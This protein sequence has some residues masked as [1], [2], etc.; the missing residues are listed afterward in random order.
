MRIVLIGGH[1]TPLLAVIKELQKQESVEIIVIT[2]KFSMEGSKKQSVESQVLQRLGIRFHYIITGRLQRHF[3]AHTFTSLAKIP[4][5]FIQSLLLLRTIRPNVVV[6]FGSYLSV[7]VC[8]SAWLF[9]IPILVHEQSSR[10]GLANRL[11]AKLA[12]KVAV[13]WPAS[14][15][16]FPKNKTVLTGNP[17][18][19]EIFQQSAEGALVAFLQSDTLPLIYVTGGNQGSHIINTTIFDILPVLLRNFR[20]IHQT[21]DAA[22]HDYERAIDLHK[23][24]PSELAQAYFVTKFIHSEDI[25]GVLHEA[26]LVISRAGAN[27][28]TELMYLGK[29]AILVPIPWAQQNEQLENAKI[30]QQQGFV[31][32]IEQKRLSG[33]VLLQTVQIMMKT[34]AI[35]QA[36]GEK[37][38]STLPK[39]PASTLAK[40]ILSL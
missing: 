20:V 35:L 7:P 16:F 32:I 4:L 21:G 33:A 27:T 38:K 25:G 12:Q 26:A 8:L 10:A 23:Q 28:V 34:Y 14:L 29:P 39:N 30:A 3:T 15:P 24:L 36:N 40:E 22:H 17:V 13:S 18:R 37:A 9:R 11:C 5:G 19:P 1:I 2:R 31:K 6:S